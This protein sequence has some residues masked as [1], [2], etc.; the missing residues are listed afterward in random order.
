MPRLPGINHQRAVKALQKAG[1]G[2]QIR[3]GA[4]VAFTGRMKASDEPRLLVRITTDPAILGGKPIVRR[5][6]D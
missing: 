5:M 2:V 3:H 6:P 4:A 1:F